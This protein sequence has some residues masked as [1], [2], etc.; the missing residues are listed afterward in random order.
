MD[1]AN[2]E[3]DFEDDESDG[4]EECENADVEPQNVTCLF[5]DATFHDAVSVFVHCRDVH[6]FNI[7]HMKR[8]HGLDCIT[9]IKLINFIRRQV[10]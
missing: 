7:C 2:A 5:C 9:Y 10:S 8:L 4:W 1:A 6:N 3:D